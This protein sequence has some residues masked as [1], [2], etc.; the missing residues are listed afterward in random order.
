MQVG[1]N[2]AHARTTIVESLTFAT[3]PTQ[4]DTVP[5]DGKALDINW[6]PLPAL[7]GIKLDSEQP[8]TRPTL[9]FNLYWEAAPIPPE[10]KLRFSLQDQTGQEWVAD[11]QPLIKD[12][13][14]QWAQ[15]GLSQLVY[16]LAITRGSS[17]WKL[18][19]F[20][21]TTGG[22]QH[23]IIRQFSTSR[24]ANHCPRKP[25]ANH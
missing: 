5:A 7:R 12:D 15:T 23:H 22:R 8:V 6:S 25:A 20:S 19:P 9:W 10:A 3:A 1:E 13:S 14:T 24:H 16:Q 21:A 18:H 11:I 17:A 2:R 4:V